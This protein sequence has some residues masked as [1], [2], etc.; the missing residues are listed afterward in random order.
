MIIKFVHVE[1]KLKTI[2]YF[3]YKYYLYYNYTSFILY[4]AFYDSPFH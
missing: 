1:K 3:K 2:L 4:C